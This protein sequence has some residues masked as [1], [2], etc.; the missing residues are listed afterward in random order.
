MLIKYQKD[1]K[2]EFLKLAE[3][4]QKHHIEIVNQDEELEFSIK[5]LVNFLKQY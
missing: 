4:Y 3:I 5:K 2:L 1:T